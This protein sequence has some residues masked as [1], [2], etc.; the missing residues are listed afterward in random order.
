MHVNG[1]PPVFTSHPFQFNDF[2]KCGHVQKQPVGVNPE[3]TPELRM[4]FFMDF[5]FMRASFSDYCSPCLGSVCIVECF[6]GLSTYL[7][8]AEEA[9]HYVW[10]FLQ[11]LKD[12]LVDLICDFLALHGSP[13]GGDIHTNLGGEKARSTNF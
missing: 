6:D 1:T 12:P 13:Q 3:K 8:V 5:G 4:R 9:S 10:M 11:K 7:I 2:K